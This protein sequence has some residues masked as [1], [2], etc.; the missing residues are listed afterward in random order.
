MS[1]PQATTTPVAFEL[2]E[3]E[4]VRAEAA[5]A[6]VS[7]AEYIRTAALSRAIRDAHREL[8]S[9]ASAVQPAAPQAVLQVN[10]DWTE[11][12]DVSGAHDQVSPG[13]GAWVES[14]VH[15]D[16][17]SRVSLAL[18]QAM[19]SGDIFESHHRTST[20][21]TEARVYSR[22]LPLVDSTGEVREWLCVVSSVTDSELLSTADPQPV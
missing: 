7:S 16:D 14:F 18:R 2:N 10:A 9:A 22:G 1:K 3:W 21:E 6:G 13:S 12:R 19:A 20:L 5:R 11:W 8:H 17:R 4:L 15:P